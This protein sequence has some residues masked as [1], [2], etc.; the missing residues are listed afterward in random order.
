[1][2]STS[3]NLHPLAHAPI[4]EWRAAIDAIEGG[5]PLADS[6]AALDAATDPAL[7]ERADLAPLARELLRNPHG[8]V[9]WLGIR[10]WR[11]LP[12]VPKRWLE[13]AARD[14]F[15]LV[16]QE[17]ARFFGMARVETALRARLLKRLLRDP[18]EFVFAHSAT[19]AGQHFP[20]S[21]LSRLLAVGDRRLLLGLASGL[22]RRKRP[23]L[24]LLKHCLTH[25]ATEVRAA[26][27]A[28]FGGVSAYLRPAAHRNA[29]ERLCGDR[30]PA[31]RAVAATHLVYLVAVDAARA[32]RLL[33]QALA[34]QE[35]VARQ[36]GNGIRA[37]AALDR[38]AAAELLICAAGRGLFGTQFAEALGAILSDD[39]AQ[40]QR[41]LLRLLDCDAPSDYFQS[42]SG[43]CDSAAARELLEAA[44]IV[45][46][47]PVL[48]PRRTAALARYWNSHLR[49]TEYAWLAAWADGLQTK[50][51]VPPAP[52]APFAFHFACGLAAWGAATRNAW[53][54]APG[55]VL[56]FADLDAVADGIASH[57][58]LF[59]GAQPRW[60]RNLCGPVVERTV[61]E[62][63][64]AATEARR[65]PILS[66]AS[67]S[68]PAVRRL[69]LPLAF[70]VTNLGGAAA[71]PITL[72][73]RVGDAVAVALLPPLAPGH[74]E[75][76]ELTLPDAP[77]GNALWVQLSVRV[78]DG[79]ALW[80]GEQRVELI[81]A[82]PLPTP[83]A[84]PFVPGKPLPDGHP[85]FFGR[86]ALF[87]DLART[88][89]SGA[90]GNV[91]ALV[92][93]RRC[94][95]TS[96]I[97]NLARNLPPGCRVLA[98]DAQGLFGGLQEALGEAAAMSAA[99]G[100]TVLAIDEFDDLEAKVRSGILPPHT[101]D[102]LRHT[103]QHSPRLAVLLV[104]THRLEDLGADYWSFLFNQALYRRLG[105]L[106][107]PEARTLI[108]QPFAACGVALEELAVRDLLWLSGG[109]PYLLQLCCHTVAAQVRSTAVTRDEVRRTVRDLVRRAEVHLHY[110]DERLAGLDRAVARCLADATAAAMTPFDALL[111]RLAALGH[112]PD[113]TGVADALTALHEQSLVESPCGC[114]W[115]HR[116]GL[117]AE[118]QRTHQGNRA[119]SAQREATLA[120][121]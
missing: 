12:A 6:V 8:E 105:P 114:C 41:L 28:G 97:N 98:L 61:T 17:V 16:R 116:I 80:V 14:D 79:R 90:Q 55:R 64:H 75:V 85:L 24:S 57:W 119:G 74:R 31:V 103:L 26:L 96:V 53:R 102:A 32:A 99:E 50:W 20:V 34:D 18:D 107:D 39:G 95:K 38:T 13:T 72:E 101:F 15:D 91:V 42:D 33:A 51:L 121:G 71:P 4:A 70:T 94:G 40:T 1:M 83:V 47:K 48:G 109:E 100:R 5:G 89:W 69:G 92:G 104:G 60:V 115:R 78:P 11:R 30:A 7:G 65:G 52:A 25:E 86:T 106:T 21:D 118:W 29:L 66:V 73:S 27:A 93:D 68:S 43:H 9:R 59:A 46:D 49:G 87:D 36:I 44:A 37:L 56:H 81:D 77:P 84:N 54:A 88:L 113:A 108:I 45:A 2:R 82:R 63:R 112:T 19:A 58:K 76:V 35:P 3:S 67:A 110:L 117:F 22:V 120:A 111:E 23:A 62:L 10:L